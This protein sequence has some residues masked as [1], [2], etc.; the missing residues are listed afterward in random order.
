TLPFRAPLLLNRLSR[1]RNALSETRVVR[2][3]SDAPGSV[4]SMDLDLPTGSPSAHN[5]SAR[6]TSGIR[7]VQA[8]E[9]ESFAELRSREVVGDE[10]E[11]NHIPSAASRIRAIEMEL[12]E[13]LS[14]AER[15]KIYNQATALEEPKDVHRAGPTYGGRNTPEQIEHDARNPA[16]AA[17]RD[18]D[19]TRRLA[20]Q[21]G[22]DLNR[23]DAGISQVHERNIQQGVYTRE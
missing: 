17:C 9:A 2:E 18:C 12:G 4:L 22:D 23:V 14:A 20:A 6:A 11:H 7:P 1:S 19:A 21:R 10:L 3:S 8:Y 5:P 15:R 16:A 13:E